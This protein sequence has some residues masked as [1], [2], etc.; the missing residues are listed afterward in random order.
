MIWTKLLVMPIALAM[1]VG[2]TDGIDP[3]YE[4]EVDMISGEAVTETDNGNTSG[5]YVTI[6]MDNG[7]TYAVY[8]M[9]ESVYKYTCPG[10]QNTIKSTIADGLLTNANVSV[11]HEK[12]EPLKLFRNGVEVDDANL[13][14]IS[15]PGNYAIVVTG[16]NVEHR[17]MGFTII[18][19]KTGGLKSYTLPSG[20]DFVQVVHDGKDVAIDNPSVVNTESD[21][22][23]ELTYRCI[24]TGMR[25]NIELNIDNTPPVFTLEGVE[26][27]SAGG[28]VK[29]VDEEKN[30]S[31]VVRFNDENVNTPNDMVLT[32]PGNYTVIVTDNAGNSVTEQFE[33][34]FYLNV[35]GWIFALLLVATVAAVLIF[36]KYSKKNLRVR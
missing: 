26:N 28:P 8:D 12:G 11:T 17:I 7:G 2:V 27:M 25:Y 31:I 9:K 32:A 33:I 35:Q 23:Y 36:M 18:G 6:P 16:V 22:L 30:D 19:E 21:G 5:Q 1:C 34:R 3:N 4:G 10:C 20:F 29:I 15:A 24:A 14:K 13:T